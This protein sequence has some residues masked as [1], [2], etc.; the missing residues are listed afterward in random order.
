MRSLQPDIT[1]FLQGSD[2]TAELEETLGRVRR[3]ECDVRD[4]LAALSSYLGLTVDEATVREVLRKDYAWTQHAI[5]AWLQ[6]RST[7]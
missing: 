5:D 2:V 3:G 1:D 6:D 7:P 4:G